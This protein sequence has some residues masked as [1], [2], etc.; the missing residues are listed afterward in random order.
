[1]SDTS[2]KVECRVHGVGHV[3][4]VCRHLAQ[5]SGVG[6][7]FGNLSDPR[8]DAW[9]Y[10][11]DL[12]LIEAGGW[13]EE[14]EAAAGIQV[15]CSGCYDVARERSSVRRPSLA[16]DGFA[17][18]QREDVLEITPEH[19]FPSRKDIVRS[20][21]GAMV[22]ILF[23]IAGDDESGDFIQGE[24]MWVSVARKTE[25][26]VFGHVDSEPVTKGPL[27]RGRAVFCSYDDVLEVG[28]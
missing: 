12:R 23:L 26:G 1:M 3:T 7:R 18:G 9:C 17:I 28:G 4:L 2:S 24:R 5:T 22:K 10:D 6:F 25:D 16:V 15:L 19:H 14:N 20:P 11:C 21:R 27:V 13:N 8:P